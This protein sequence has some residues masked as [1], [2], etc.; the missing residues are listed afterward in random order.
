MEVFDGCTG[1]PLVVAFGA[2]AAFG[3]TLVA[4]AHAIQREKE[5]QERVQN[6]QRAA[7]YGRDRAREEEV[8]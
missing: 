8:K 5:R 7:R 2:G 1:D 3:M 6:E 4:I